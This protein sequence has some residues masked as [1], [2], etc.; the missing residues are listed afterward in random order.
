[1]II[2]MHVQL[3]VGKYLSCVVP[4][5]NSGKVLS[6]LKLHYRLTLVTL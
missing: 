3:T 1:M 4:V 5:S 2:F 6:F